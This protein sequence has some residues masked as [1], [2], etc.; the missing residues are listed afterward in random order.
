MDRAPILFLGFKRPLHTRRV[1]ES[2]ARNREV[3]QS[4]LYAFVDGP[5]K[6]EDHEKVEEVI[7]IIKSSQWCANV[8]L[9]DSKENRG[10][11]AQTIDAV[12]WLCREKGRVIVIE[13]DIVLSPHFLAYM[14]NAL[15]RYAS[16]ERVMDVGGYMFPIRQLSA[17]TGFLREGGGWGWGTWD[18]AWS[19]FEPDGRKLLEHFRGDKKLV[20]EFNYRNSYDYYAMLENQVKGNIGGW[21]VRWYATK[22]FRNGL[23]LAPT[24]SLTKNIGFDKTGTNTGASAL[25]YDT[26]LTGTP[27]A[28]FPDT[29]EES[30]ELVEAVVAF[31]RSI[32]RP[33]L[34][35]R[36]KGI[37]SRFLG[38]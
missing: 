18:R 6:K 2:L 5:K 30:L 26:E 21:D 35:G 13:D 11:P 36:V 27:I 33:T 34:L 37:A 23:S 17:E 19:A 9:H 8:H 22:F 16:E 1:L 4:D 38:K 7:E 25:V 15:D 20:Y 28:A 14:N 24:R 31:L 3:Q 32:N 10:C 29:I 12:S